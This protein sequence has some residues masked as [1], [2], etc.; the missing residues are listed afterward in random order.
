M[1]NKQHQKKVEDKDM[2]EFI[3]NAEKFFEKNQKKIYYALIVIIALVTIAFLS[4][5]YYFEP[6]NQEVA[7]KLVWCEKQLALDSFALALNGDGINAG[8]AEICS[9]YSI[10]TAKNEAAIGAAVCSYHLGKYD[11]AIE[12]AKKANRKSFAFAPAMDGLIGDCYS[13]KGDFKEAISYYH[14]A[15]EYNNVALSPRFLKKAAA[16]YL[17]EF[18]DSKKALECYQT[19]KDKYFDSQEA[20]D[21]DKYIEVASK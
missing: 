11:D 1:E 21:I 8:Y 7:V 4:K 2:G 5:R 12:Y 14:K 17:N 15:A 18:N 13:Q 9:S 10:T 6:K 20:V 19:I 16:L 3:S